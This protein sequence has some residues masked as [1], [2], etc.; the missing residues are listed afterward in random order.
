LRFLLLHHPHF[1]ILIDLIKNATIKASYTVTPNESTPKELHTQLI[2]IIQGNAPF[3]INLYHPKL[4][5]VIRRKTTLCKRIIPFNSGK[6]V[7]GRVAFPVGLRQRLF[8]WLR[9]RVFAWEE[10]F[11]R[12]WSLLSCFLAQEGDNKERTYYRRLY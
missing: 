9:R 3:Q 2:Y 10:V 12:V 8:V 6:V 5:L 7:C 4:N 1:I 11:L